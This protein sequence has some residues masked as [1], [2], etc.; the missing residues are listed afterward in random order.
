MI[1]LFIIKI[2]MILFLNSNSYT[3]ILNAN[4]SNFL[5]KKYVYLILIASP[6]PLFLRKSQLDPSAF[7]VTR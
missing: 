4:H 6:R 5:S 2:K 1:Y 7:L 3:Q